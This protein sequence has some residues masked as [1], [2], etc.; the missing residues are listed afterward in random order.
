MFLPIDELN[1]LR[2]KVSEIVHSVQTETARYDSI[3]FLIDLLASTVI[4]MV[5]E[6][7]AA[8]YDRAFKTGIDGWLD[9]SPDETAR[10]DAV[11]TPVGGKSFADRIM[12]Y[13]SGDL[14]QFVSKVAVLAETDGH[15]CRS[16][17][18]LAAGE[19]LSQAGLT[20]RK[21][22]RGVLDA[23]EREKH[24]ALEGVTLPLDA[25]FE[26][27]GYTAPAPGLFGAPDLDCNCRCELKINA[28]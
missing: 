6:H 10:R 7:L 19:R 22:W 26:I 2:A 9:V 13:A 21:T 15:R 17:G 25:F 8:E 3:D 1:T 27:D 5:E 4:P 20:V 14:K 12:D 28:L 24:V 23:R 16:E 11:Y 18:I